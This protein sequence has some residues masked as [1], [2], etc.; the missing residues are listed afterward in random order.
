[1]WTK[2]EEGRSRCSQV[3]DQKQNGYRQTDM[4]KAIHSLFFEGGHKEMLDQGT[5]TLI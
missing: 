1:V 4:C 5:I 2:F 3:I